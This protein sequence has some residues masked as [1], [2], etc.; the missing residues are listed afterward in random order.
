MSTDN[1]ELYGQSYDLPED[2]SGIMD[3]KTG[4]VISSD[5][6]TPLDV[7][8]A[9]AKETGIELRDPNEGCKKCYGRGYIGRDSMTKQPIPCTCIYPAKSEDDEIQDRIAEQTQLQNI[10]LYRYSSEIFHYQ[11]PGFYLKT[12]QYLLK[13]Y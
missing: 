11:I 4:D 8:K 3:T 9:V 1:S 2:K 10:P 12:Y 13:D 6:L 5:E 7:I